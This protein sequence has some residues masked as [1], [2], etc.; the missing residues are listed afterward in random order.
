MQDLN[1]WLMALAF[2]L[3]LLLTLAMVIRRVTREVPV[4]HALSGGVA[5]TGAKA[6]V[7]SVAA[8]A[9]KH[10]EQVHEH[11]EK[12]VEQVTQHVD[13]RVEQVSEHVEHVAKKAE[14]IHNTIQ[15]RDV[16]EVG[17][18]GQG[19][20]RV[21]RRI[22]GPA[23]YTVKGDK[24][25]GRYFTSDSPDYETTES[26]L[27]FSNEASAQK[28]GFLRW[29][30]DA[31]HDP[32]RAATLVGAESAAADGPYGKGSSRASADGGGPAGWLVK[33]NADSGLYHGPDSPYYNQTIAE[34]WFI[35]EATAAAAGF[36][37][38]DINIG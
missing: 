2:V 5:G 32:G 26:E 4:T 21:T 38:W 24:D 29:D 9:A 25:T 7:A 22:L 11:V 28:A 14:D 23:G 35:D 18:Y 36:K 1:W 19:S 8:G 33:G 3:G 27:W 37:R 34:V 12:R 13:K 20:I 15:G 30:A 16:L 17:P 6:A 10:V 31:D